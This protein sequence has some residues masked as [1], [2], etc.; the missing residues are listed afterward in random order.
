MQLS[1]RLSAV[2]GLV[3]PGSRL[4]DV[5]TDHGYVPIFLVQSGRVPGAV[6]MDVNEGPL[7]RAREHI[8][9]AGLEAYIQTRLSDGVSALRPG[10]ADAVVIAG[11]GGPL[12]ARILS[13]GAR[14]LS[15]CREFILQPQS[16]VREFRTWLLEHNFRIEQEEMVREDG[17]FYPIIRAVHGRMR[18]ESGEQLRFG[19]L[20][21][22]KRDPVLL[23][24]L[25]RELKVNEEIRKRLKTSESGAGKSRLE[26]I[27]EERR[28]IEA[29]LAYYEV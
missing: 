3:T 25:K 9:A 13:D 19:R 15:D 14:V 28:E 1:K 26:Q 23:E 12:M 29:A 8:R 7:A 24:F 27:E 6:A 17:K 5:G 10:E 20:L 4:A 22:M 16:E 21:L 11:M 18:W 2:A